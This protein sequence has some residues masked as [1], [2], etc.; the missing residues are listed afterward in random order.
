MFL[1]PSELPPSLGFGAFFFRRGRSLFGCRGRV[2]SSFGLGHNGA[3]H[4]LDSFHR[5]Y[6]N[7][8]DAFYGDVHFCFMELDSVPSA[9]LV[10]L[11]CRFLRIC[12]W[13]E[14]FRSVFFGGT[15]LHRL[16]H[17]FKRKKIQGTCI[18]FHCGCSCPTGLV[19]S[20]L[21]SHGQSLFSL[22]WLHFRN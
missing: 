3:G 4:F 8:A 2:F 11:V 15:R 7:V 1:R 6:Q 21:L 22:L 14:I 10:G 20:E 18:F 9:A 16:I 19:H 17:Q 13:Y 5:P 12:Y